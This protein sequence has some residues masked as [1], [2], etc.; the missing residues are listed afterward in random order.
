MG[1]VIWSR[2]KAEGNLA[3]ENWGD[4]ALKTETPTRTEGDAIGQV[5]AQEITQETEN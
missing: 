4:E 3:D 1:K 5:D 2:Y